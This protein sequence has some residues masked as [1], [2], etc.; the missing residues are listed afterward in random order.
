ML[1]RSNPLVSLIYPTYWLL[2][3]SMTRDNQT[4][5]MPLQIVII[6]H[7]ALKSLK[8]ELCLLVLLFSINCSRGGKKPSL[9]TKISFDLPSPVWPFVNSQKR[10]LELSCM[11]CLLKI[12]N[13]SRETFSNLFNLW[14]S[15]KEPSFSPPQWKLDEKRVFLSTHLLF[16]NPVG[17][18]LVYFKFGP[19]RRSLVLSSNFIS[20][21]C[22]FVRLSFC[23]KFVSQSVG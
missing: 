13:S 5:I 12:C 11:I 6:F 21:M 18:S 22:L 1:F 9:D 16:S 8:T 10:D 4:K 15:E 14:I 3:M 20:S 23:C 7:C 2:A 19:Y 17:P